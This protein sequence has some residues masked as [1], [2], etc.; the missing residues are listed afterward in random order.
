ME[1]GK[2]DPLRCGRT[3]A[4]FHRTPLTEA[5]R[6]WLVGWFAGA[7][8]THEYGSGNVLQ[9]T[10]YISLSHYPVLSGLSLARS[11]LFLFSL[12]SFCLVQQDNCQPGSL[13]LIKL[14]RRQKQHSN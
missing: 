9:P 1:L 12:L 6:C 2:K 14:R 7:R 10:F 5:G 13:L 11:C 4:L 8:G 3:I